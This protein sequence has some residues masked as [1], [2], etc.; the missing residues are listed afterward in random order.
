M[1]GLVV[2]GGG[3]CPEPSQGAL[4]SAVRTALPNSRVFLFTDATASDG[5]TAGQAIGEAKDRNTR[6]NYV[7]TGS[8]SPVDP[9]YYRGARE[10][11]GQVM[12]MRSWDL[13]GIAQAIESQLSD[14][15]ETILSV[16]GSLAGAPR[17]FDVPV[18][19]TV[20]RLQIATELDLGLTA[21]LIRPNGNAVADGDPDASI[22]LLRQVL[23]GGLP[24]SPDLH[25]RR[26][27]A[28]H[29]AGSRIRH[30]EFGATTF[31]DG[32]GQ[33]RAASPPSI[34]SHAGADSRFRLARCRAPAT[35]RAL[36][37]KRL[38]IRRS[39]WWT[40]RERLYGPEPQ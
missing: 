21:T 17:T 13:D 40:N 33:R 31:L 10:T 7:V 27:S 1:Q 38:R 29:L 11:G 3:D 18:D 9:V 5:G 26:A 6:L 20:R 14:D 25:H 36:L 19:P 15:L 30:P 8:C 39:V 24:E 32:A 34:S 12:L 22:T 4:L 23:I 16:R 37:T 28:G 35:G 2:D